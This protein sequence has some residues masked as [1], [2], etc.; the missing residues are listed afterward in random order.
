MTE[1]RAWRPMSRG[2]IPLTCNTIFS[3]PCSQDCFSVHVDS[4]PMGTKGYSG[5][6]FKF[7]TLLH[8]VLKLRRLVAFVQLSLCL[9]T[10]TILRFYLLAYR[11]YLTKIGNFRHRY[12]PDMRNC[13]T[14]ENK[15]TFLL[16]IILI[17]SIWMVIYYFLSHCLLIGVNGI[18]VV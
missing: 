9:S 12:Q 2:S 3:S 5:R 4:Y 14:N 7:A 8:P 6:N 11:P 10:G 18:I 17:I 1:L 16:R 15:V 13:G